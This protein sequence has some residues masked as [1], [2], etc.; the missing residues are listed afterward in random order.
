[1]M[2]M[3]FVCS[4][5]QIWKIRKKLVSKRHRGGYSKKY[6]ISLL[7]TEAFVKWRS[8]TFVQ[9]PPPIR[10][11]ECNVQLHFTERQVNEML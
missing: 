2:R 6:G 9:K 3:H 7:E 4:S 10:L 5:V 11:F 1:M 8:G